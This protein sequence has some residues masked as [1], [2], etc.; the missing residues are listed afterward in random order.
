M[1]Q[2]SAMADEPVVSQPAATMIAAIVAAVVT[3]IALGFNIY[4]SSRNL[5]IA[6]QSVDATKGGLKHA[7]T[8]ADAATI[9]AAAA[10]DDVESAK[11][12]SYSALS[13]ASTA[14]TAIKEVG[15]AN[16]E[17]EKWRL[18]EETFRTLR[19]ASDNAVADSTGTSLMGLG[20]LGALVSHTSLI[21]IVDIPFLEEVNGVVRDSARSIVMSVILNA[22]KHD[23]PEV[24]APQAGSSKQEEDSEGDGGAVRQQVK[25]IIVT[26]EVRSAALVVIEIARL[27]NTP[28][29]K[30]PAFIK[31][32]ASGEVAEVSVT[33]AELVAA[34]GLKDAL[35]ISTPSVNRQNVERNIAEQTA[36][37]IL[38]AIGRLSSDQLPHLRP[39][40]PESGRS[41]PS[42]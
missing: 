7:E 15:R 13:A 42:M 14:Q 11:R 1:I 21:Q 23:K 31:T 28:L 40:G 26:L 30:V 33:D 9:S 24:E 6:K 4:I 37:N 29:S 18:R 8:S 16:T 35:T 19:W 2:L 27:N 36:T 22:S 39:K 3:L 38:P 34:V 25:N 41:G 10:K 17:A 20:V 12:S 32:I 5:A